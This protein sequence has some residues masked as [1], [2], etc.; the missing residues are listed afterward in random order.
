MLRFRSV[1][2]ALTQDALWVFCLAAF[3]HSDGG[4]ATTLL[5]LT[6]K[7]K[8]PPEEASDWGC[9]PQWGFTCYI[10]RIRS[11]LDGAR[12]FSYS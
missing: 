2:I 3:G 11:S 4:A 6:G 8:R 1:P 7:N 12:L 10:G 5:L 9:Y